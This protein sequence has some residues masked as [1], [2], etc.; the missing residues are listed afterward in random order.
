MIERYRDMWTWV[1]KCDAF[2]I[3]TNGFRKRSNRAVMGRGIAREANK[4]FADL[5]LAVGE[6]IEMYGNVPVPITGFHPLVTFPVKPEQVIV[7]RHARN[8][9]SRMR[10]QFS[11]GHIAPGWAAKADLDLIARSAAELRAMADRRKWQRVFVPRPGCGNGE[12]SWSQVK[13]ILAQHFDDRFEV[14]C[15]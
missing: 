11:P 9:I 12:L 8:I 4:R 10:R 15:R 3:T 6:A 7:D 2:C 5:D 14:F 1:D 13:P